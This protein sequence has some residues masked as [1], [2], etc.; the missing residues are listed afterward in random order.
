MNENK[1]VVLKRDVAELMRCKYIPYAKETII[2]RAIPYIDG[3]K[4]VAR[5]IMWGM[6]ESGVYDTKSRKIKRK[7]ARVVGDVMG[8]Y[9]PHGDKAIYD[10]ICGMTDKYEGL[11]E[12]LII[13]QGNFGK[14]WSGGKRRL[15]ASAMRYTE[16]KLSPIGVEMMDGIKENAVEF[17]SNFDETEKEPVLLPSKFPNVI[18]NTFDGIAVAM[19]SSIPSYPLKEAC[20]AAIAMLK[21]QAVEADDIVDILGAPDF[22]FGGWLHAS[23]EE[24]KKLVETGKGTLEMTGVFHQEGNKLIIDDIPYNT[25]FEKVFDEI[26]ELIKSGSEP[27][28]KDVTSRVGKSSKG[29]AVELKKGANIKEVAKNLCRATSLR[30][31][32]SFNTRIIWK[33]KPV[34]LGIFELLQHWIEFRIGCVRRVYKVRYDKAIA[35]RHK[36]ETWR[37]I[38]DKLDEVIVTIRANKKAVAS[39][40]LQEN[41]GLSEVQANYLLGMTLSSIC[42]DMVEKSMNDL[43]KC[44]EE[45]KYILGVLE[46]DD[47]VKKVIIGELEYIIDKYG[48]DRNTTVTAPVERENAKKDG[49]PEI[50]DELVS[51]CVTRN[52]L[53]KAQKVSMN[54]VIP[55]SPKID[56]KDEFIGEN[57]MCSTRDRILLFTSQGYCYKIPVNLIEQSRG[58][59]RMSI[60]DIVERKDTGK[61]LYAGSDNNEKDKFVLIYGNGSGRVIWLKD[62]TGPSKVQKSCFKSDE[63]CDIFVTKNTK[64]FIITTAL[65]AAYVDV[66]Y[67]SN[68]DIKSAFKA[69]R[70]NNGEVIYG[71]QPIDRVPD[72]NSIS[73]EKYSKGYTVKIGEDKLWW[74][75]EMLAEKNGNQYEDYEDYEEDEQ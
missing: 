9:H 20:L 71:L 45:I 35:E 4:P 19:G 31:K 64:F 62:F 5:R 46:N 3:F 57:I 75:A 44:E 36:L 51:V 22:T 23:R 52:G 6:Y 12:P 66:S 48:K 67:I 73:L 69:T 59:M 47:N 41:F 27:D 72:I 63:E 43:I 26:K 16:C 49:K 29:L 8:K 74:T 58:N 34:E 40:K 37:L 50:P 1:V 61:L 39:M 54:G 65:K 33:G 10:V 25:N 2:N 56:S 68:M 17:I 70:I 7:C 14:A 21:G 18:V 28:L 55:N 15:K 32:I 42:E 53:I 24:Q 38:A 60:W 30:N 13:G 11:N